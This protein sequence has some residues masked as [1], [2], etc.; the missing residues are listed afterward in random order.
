MIRTFIAIGSNLGEPLEQVKQAV[1]ALR[2]SPHCQL[3]TCS[4][5]YR[6]E[7]IGPAGQ[8]DYINGACELFTSLEPLELLDLLQNIEQQHGRLRNERWG[9]RTLDLDLILYGDQQI[10]IPRLQVPHPEATQRNFV[11]HPMAEIDPTLIFP[12]GTPM[13]ELLQQ[14]PANGIEPL[15][16]P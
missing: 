12:N 3:G 4:S 2:Q 14:C 1:A 16:T 11:L 10:D 8:P 5:W 13:S 15:N 6:S 7:P 9:P